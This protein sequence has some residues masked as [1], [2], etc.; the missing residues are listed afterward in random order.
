MKVSG[1]D[2]ALR[3]IYVK[4][5]ALGENK[6][7][8]AISKQLAE[9][10]ITE[11][12][13]GFRASVDPYEKPWAP[14]Q[15]RAGKTLLDSGRLRNS[16]S[17]QSVTARGFKVGTNVIYAPVHQYGATIKPKKAKALR[18]K[19]PMLGPAPKGGG[20]GKRSG[21][22]GSAFVFAKSVTIPMRR[23]MPVKTLGLGAKWQRAFN[24]AAAA[25]L[26]RHMISK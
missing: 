9:Q 14:P 22:T 23:M 7:R 12:R 24:R 1:P 18:F 21:G 8:I 11:V 13:K 15:F 25:A 3:A 17:Y 19:V 4:V 6:L 16:F 2:G 5:R 26:R 20:K 10:A